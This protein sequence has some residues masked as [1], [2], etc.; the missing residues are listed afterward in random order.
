MTLVAPI[1]LLRLVPLMFTLIHE[2]P[3]HLRLPN[4]LPTHLPLL[5]LVPFLVIAVIFALIV[6]SIPYRITAAQDQKLLFK[7]L[8]Q[9]R[10][11]RVSDLQRIEPG[12]LYIQ[13]GMSGYVLHHRDSGVGDSRLP[14]ADSGLQESSIVVDGVQPRSATAANLSR[15]LQGGCRDIAA[16]VVF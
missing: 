3:G 5:L 6:A 4:R 16:A 7:S 12:H 8:M 13:A 15:T 9:A 2:F 10:E 14:A 1:L 11:V